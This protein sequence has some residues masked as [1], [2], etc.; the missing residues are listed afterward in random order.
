MKLTK[1]EFKKRFQ[2]S[3]ELIEHNILEWR[4]KI[5]RGNRAEIMLS[6]FPIGYYPSSNRFDDCARVVSGY[7][8]YF[9]MRDGG[10]YMESVYSPLIGG[11]ISGWDVRAVG[12]LEKHRVT[13]GAITSLPITSEPIDDT[14]TKLLIMADELPMADYLIKKRAINRWMFKD[15]TDDMM[16]NLV[17]C[18]NKQPQEKRDRLMALL[19]KYGPPEGPLGE[20][21]MHIDKFRSM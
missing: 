21:L 3:E 13:Y 4:Q 15:P 11:H 16:L 9:V 10:V 5:E 6:E 12:D 19:D 17:S 18:I 20:A 7:N 14:T 1:T 8:T 2:M